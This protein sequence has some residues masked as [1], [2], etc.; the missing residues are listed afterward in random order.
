ML[1]VVEGYKWRNKWVCRGRRFDFLFWLGRKMVRNAENVEDMV[2]RGW[3][4]GQYARGF[5]GAVEPQRSPRARRIVCGCCVSDGLQIA[6]YYYDAGNRRVR[7]IIMNGGLV[8]NIPNGTTDYIWSG[9]Q[10]VEER[11]ASNAP[12]RQY[13]WGQYI[14]ECIQLTKLVPLGAQNLAAGSYYLLQ[15]L[16]YRAVALT[17]SSGQVVEA[18]DTDAYGNTLISTGPGADGV[19]FTDDDVQ[20]DYGANNVIYCGYSYDAETELYYVR[21]RTY[22]PVLGR[23]I[24][25][26]P[27]GFQG[28]INLYEYVG[29]GPVGGVDPWGHDSWGFGVPSGTSIGLPWGYYISGYNNSGEV[30][31]P[32]P[33]PA[34]RPRGLLHRSKRPWWQGLSE[35]D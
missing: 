26:D 5:G 23:W 30:V 13:V 21:N 24:Q 22:N 29:S 15:D 1:A 8:G 3:P 32:L 25:R 2:G 31:Q 11:N 4:G 20:S 10:V 12:I 34:V 14:D 9:W 28:G 7:K 16:L 6:A 17:N 35:A 18:Y 19:W 33:G 27:I